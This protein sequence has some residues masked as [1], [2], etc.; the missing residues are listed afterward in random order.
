M[1]FVS[2]GPTDHVIIGLDSGLAQNRRQSITW[3]YVDSIYD[4]ISRHLATM[5]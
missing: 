3:T 5:S 4:I 1:K 2:E